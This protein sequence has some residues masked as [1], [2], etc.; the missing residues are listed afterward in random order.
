MELRLGD[1]GARLK[2]NFE[3]MMVNVLINI[4]CPEYVQGIV[5][6]YALVE[7]HCHAH[8]SNVQLKH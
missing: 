2:G 3:S 8:Q 7:K 5:G 1:E 6:R 4:K